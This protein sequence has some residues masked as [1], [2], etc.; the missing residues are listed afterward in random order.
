MANLSVVIPCFNEFKVADAIKE[1]ELYNIEVIIVDDGSDVPIPEAT[2]RHEKNMGYGA[3]LKTGIRLATRD[4][5]LT[6]DGDG[7]HLVEDVIRLWLYFNLI[8]T[9]MIVGVRK[10]TEVSLMRYFGR[11]GLSLIASCWAN[12][13][14]M[15]LNSGLRIFRREL[16]M[17]YM[18]I[19]C[20]TYSFTTTLTLMFLIDGYKVEWMPIK[21]QKR[22]Q[23]KSKVRT[24]KHGLITLYYITRIGFALRTRTVRKWKRKLFGQST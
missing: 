13:W 14:L 23:G 16:A 19:L 24:I 10:I 17:S 2:I 7:Q 3:A 12:R 20:D 8:E 15:D 9:D 11:K 6:M 5:I 21:V 4:Y 22:I 1:F 18:S